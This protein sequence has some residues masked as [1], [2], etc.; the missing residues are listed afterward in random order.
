M[1]KYDLTQ[2]Q[3]QAVTV[4]NPTVFDTCDDCPVDHVSWNDPQQ[5][6]RSLND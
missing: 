6:V 2:E 5:F 3:W 1:G 4:S